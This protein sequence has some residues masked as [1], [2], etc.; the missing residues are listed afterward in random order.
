MVSSLPPGSYEGVLDTHIAPH[1]S[2]PTTWEF[3]SPPLHHP[4]AQDCI[5]PNLDP[6]DS[7]MKPIWGCYDCWKKFCTTWDGCHHPSIALSIK[8]SKANHHGKCSWYPLPQN[9]CLQGSSCFAHLCAARWYD[10]TR[11]FRLTTHWFQDTG[12]K[13][14]EAISLQ[15][16]RGTKSQGMTLQY[17]TLRLILYSPKKKQCLPST[18]GISWNFQVSRTAGNCDLSFSSNTSALGR[19]VPGNPP[20][21]RSATLH[22]LN[23]M[24]NKLYVM[25]LW[26]VMLYVVLY[27]M[28]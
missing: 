10:Q 3:P 14:S 27:V 20:R 23:S 24:I 26:Y 7:H 12:G 25:Y 8:Q 11:T 15:N 22:A 21:I 18:P 13:C 19:A 1:R 5:F 16:W 4:E 6:Q 2:L 28:L 9:T 17:L